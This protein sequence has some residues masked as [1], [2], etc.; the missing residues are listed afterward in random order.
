MCKVV[1]DE[2]DLEDVLYQS[3]AGAVK[4]RD[5]VYGWGKQIE[6]SGVG[7]YAPHKNGFSPATLRNFLEMPAS[8]PSS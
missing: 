2:M 3:A 7:F 4:V 8:P 6:G 1:R 5:M